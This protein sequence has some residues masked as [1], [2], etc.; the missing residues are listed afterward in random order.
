MTEPPAWLTPSY[1]ELREQP[2]WVMGDMVEREHE[3]PGAILGDPS[4]APIAAA[5]RAALGA[6]GVVVVTGCGTSEHAARAGA[7]LLSE[8]LGDPGG[9]SAVVARNAFDAALEPA[10][11][12][13][14]AVSHGG[15]STATLDA[16]R[17]ARGVGATTCLITAAE[18]SEAHAVADLLF[19]T[20]IVDASW[21][22]TVGYLSPVLAAA[23]IA[24]CLGGNPP[25][26]A[27]LTDLIRSCDEVL[28]RAAAVSAIA[29]A[30]R[31]LVVG[32][33]A[34]E[35]TAMEQTLKI[36]EGAWIPTAT[37]QVETLL[38]GHLPGTDG[39][40]GLI[41]YLLDP[42]ARPER[43]RRVAQALRAARA[44]GASC[45]LV[46]DGGSAG[47]HGSEPMLVLPADGTGLV[48]ALTAGALALQ[49]LTL[50][51]AERRGTNPDLLRRE[52]VRY[53]TAALLGE[54]K[55]RMFAPPP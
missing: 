4:A 55:V 18:T 13:C 9:P 16:L 25:D 44:V 28:Q 41:A 34:D 42:R 37:R 24:G 3:L 33:G 10:R 50:A 14:I 20:P 27:V 8:S 15:T 51:L 7:A 32:S 38:H 40:T 21:C 29:D 17:A 2:P 46:T 31:L 35:I 19:C 48:G 26:A 1:P 23:A 6:G 39:R 47:E 52:D 12:M 49:R 54:H 30:E 43:A 53:R 11:G 5:V 45:L 36:E 22:H